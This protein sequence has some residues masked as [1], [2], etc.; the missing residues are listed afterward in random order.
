MS[1]DGPIFVLFGLRRDKGW[2]PGAL[3]AAPLA[4]TKLPPSASS[5]PPFISHQTKI[6]PFMQGTRLVWINLSEMNPRPVAWQQY[7]VHT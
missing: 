7:F 4:P 3:E 2:V 6:S 1:A 5:H